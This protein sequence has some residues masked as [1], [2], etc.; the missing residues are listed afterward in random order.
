[1]SRETRHF[2]NAEGISREEIPDIDL[3]MDQILGF[4]KERLAPYEREEN[5]GVLTKTM[6][7]N[8]VKAKVIERPRKK[9]YGRK[10][11]ERLIMLYHL[12]NVLTLKDIGELFGLSEAAEDF[13][14]EMFREFERDHLSRLRARYEERWETLSSRE[15]TAE[16]MELALEA[17]L[18]KRLA[19]RLLDEL[20]KGS[21]A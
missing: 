5:S 16:V 17:D 15:K 21:Q 12:K 6:I 13:G 14:Y 11:L 19:E 20:T 18:K 10:Q 9:K 2:L 4:L 1:M 8:Y 3:Y 7:N